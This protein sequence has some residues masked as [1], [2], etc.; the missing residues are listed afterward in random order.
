MP[1]NRNL[2]ESDCTL[3]TYNG[4]LSILESVIDY[5][6]NKPSVSSQPV[7]TKSEV[8]KSF[9]SIPATQRELCM[10]RQ[11]RRIKEVVYGEHLDELLWSEGKSATCPVSTT[12]SIKTADTS[13]SEI[14]AT[15]SGFCFRHTVEE[16][17]EPVGSTVQGVSA[18]AASQANIPVH[19]SKMMQTTCPESK[20]VARCVKD[21]VYGDGETERPFGQSSYSH[22]TCEA[23]Q[24]PVK[25][26]KFCMHDSLL[27]DSVPASIAVAKQAFDMPHAHWRSAIHGF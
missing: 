21:A 7:E 10:P 1:F 4:D 17:V 20:R 19:K 3:K 26:F 18:T 11:A 25:H 6:V 14:S 23:P 5:T 9:T 8:L 24:H 13:A 2:I 15:G 12:V 22:Q 27:T 16:D